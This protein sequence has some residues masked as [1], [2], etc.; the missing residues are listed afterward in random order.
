M[1]GKSWKE[2]FKDYAELEKWCA[3]HQP[4]YK[5]PIPEV[6]DYFARRYRIEG[7]ER[8]DKNR[9]ESETRNQSSGTIRP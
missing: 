4:F 7:F 3:D 5:Q 2:P 1:T 9:M 6:V 8:N